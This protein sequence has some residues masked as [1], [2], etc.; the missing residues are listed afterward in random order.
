MDVSEQNHLESN[1]RGHMPSFYLK[2][3]ILICFNG[4]KFLF[5][6]FFCDKVYFIAFDINSTVRFGWTCI[7]ASPAANAN[8][9]VYFRDGQF[10][11]VQYHIHR[12]GRAV[13]RAGSAI[14][15]I[16]INN[17]VF[18]NKTGNADLCDLLSFRRQWPDGPCRTNL[19]TQ[20]TF[21]ITE[22]GVIIHK[23][24]HQSMKT[25]LKK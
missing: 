5:N 1:K 8:L 21:E 10:S 14:C 2:R 19:A 11:F 9:V 18:L 3:E 25:I 4:F 16:G 15:V 13:F 12:F 17:T 6:R 23:R 22:S 24:L 20:G 7:F